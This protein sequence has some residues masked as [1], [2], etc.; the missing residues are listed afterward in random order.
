MQLKGSTIMVTGGASGLGGATVRM[1]V[2]GGGNAVI[3]DLKEAEGQALAKELGGGARF[4]RTDVA[5]EA[6]AQAAV[7]A[8]LGTY[9]RMDGLVNCAGI[10]HGEKVVGR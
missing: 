8:A 5:D 3:A 6:S 7:S 10:V 1:V 4:V 9:R 2:E